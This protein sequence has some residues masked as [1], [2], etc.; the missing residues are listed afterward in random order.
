M[1]HYILSHIQHI[2]TPLQQEPVNHTLF[3]S[4]I[5]GGREGLLPS[6]NENCV[7]RPTRFTQRKFCASPNALRSTEILC[8]AQPASLNI[9]CNYILQIP[10]RGLSVFTVLFCG[11]SFMYATAVTTYHYCHHCHS[12]HYWHFCHCSHYCHLCHH[13]H[14]CHLCH[15]YP[16]L[17]CIIIFCT[18]V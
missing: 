16:P 9:Q 14:Y 7:L 1:E 17:L 4:V 13:C 10:I 6:C 11:L 18:Y 15:D 8:F 12:C 3:L 2:S 5:Y